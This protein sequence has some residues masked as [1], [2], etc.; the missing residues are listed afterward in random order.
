ME[1]SPKSV[2]DVLAASFE[3]RY[4]TEQ[5]RRMMHDKV[6]GGGAWVGGWVG[7]WWWGG[8]V[9]VRVCVGWGG[10]GVRVRVRVCV[11]GGMVVVVVCFCVGGGGGGGGVPRDPR[12]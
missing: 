7:G 6:D 10:G 2:R 8:G 4:G 12:V 1:D 9:C 5:A 11:G 3:L